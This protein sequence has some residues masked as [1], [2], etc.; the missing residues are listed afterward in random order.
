[1]ANDPKKKLTD[2]DVANLIADVSKQY[3]AYID[4]NSV[5]SALACDVIEEDYQRDLTHPLS[6]QYKA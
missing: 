6:I 3:E 2:K 4:I 5:N 1:M